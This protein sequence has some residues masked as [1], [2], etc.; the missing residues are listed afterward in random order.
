M[1]LKGIG[2]KTVIIGLDL[3]ELMLELDQSVEGV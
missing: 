3:K 2:G 1:I